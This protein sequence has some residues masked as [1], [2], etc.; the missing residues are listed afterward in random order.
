MYFVDIEQKLSEKDK[1]IEELT[2]KL[3]NMG[4]GIDKLAEKIE[5][6]NTVEEGKKEKNE[7][8]HAVVKTE[9]FPSQNCL[10][11]IQL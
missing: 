3:R 6:I 1:L 11:E 9:S 4:Q 5:K 7:R 2:N 8:K 10:C